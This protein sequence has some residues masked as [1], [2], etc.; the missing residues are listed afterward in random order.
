MCAVD[1]TQESGDIFGD[2][3]EIFDGR[4]VHTAQSHQDKRQKN[5]RF[6]NSFPPESSHVK[7]PVF[8]WSSHIV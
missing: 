7:I 6:Q 2:I 3:F 4:K 5:T 8:N 1:I